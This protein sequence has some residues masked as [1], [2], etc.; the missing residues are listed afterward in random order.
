MLIN[1]NFGLLEDKDKK[2]TN[3]LYKRCLHFKS[4]DMYIVDDDKIITL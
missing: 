4:C 3:I 1:Y 2:V